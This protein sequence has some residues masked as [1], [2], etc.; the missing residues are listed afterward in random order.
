MNGCKIAL[1]CFMLGFLPS[2]MF[3]LRSLDVFSAVSVVNIREVR[4]LMYYRLMY[5]CVRVWLLRVDVRVMLMMMV[6]IVD[7]SMRV[8]QSCVPVRMIMPF[9]DVQPDSRSHQ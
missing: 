6:F 5:M 7:V 8:F 3:N 4:M 9:S 1:A 2:R